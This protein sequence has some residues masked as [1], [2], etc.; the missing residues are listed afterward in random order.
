MIYDVIEPFF[1]RSKGNNG[2]PAKTYI[3]YLFDDEE[4]T[5]GIVFTRLVLI[6]AKDQTYHDMFKMVKRY[7]G[8]LLMK[9]VFAIKPETLN[10]I[11]IVLLNSVGQ[12]KKHNES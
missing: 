1:K 10:S 8:K 4:K 3:N 7:K 12:I 2:Y 11:M 9:Q 6:D 5:S